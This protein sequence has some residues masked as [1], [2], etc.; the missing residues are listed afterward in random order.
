M[1]FGALAVVVLIVGYGQVPFI[2][3]GL[4]LSFGTY[5]LVKKL[6]GRSVEPTPGLAFETGAVLPIALGFLIWLGPPGNR[7]SR[8]SAATGS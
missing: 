4:A 2:A 8:R 5:S 7:P 6:A 1:G 3:L